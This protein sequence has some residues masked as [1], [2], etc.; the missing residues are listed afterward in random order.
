MQVRARIS[1]CRSG[2]EVR[3]LDAEPGSKSKFAG[4]TRQ[5]DMS[6]HLMDKRKLLGARLC[7]CEASAGVY[8]AFALR[9]KFIE[10]QRAWGMNSGTLAR[11]KR[12]FRLPKSFS[13]PF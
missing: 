11:R 13:L 2:L 4:A 8:F 1:E 9:L 5:G 3:L 7:P 12:V 6:A 10:D